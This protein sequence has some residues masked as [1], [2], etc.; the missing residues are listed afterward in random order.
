M[1]W[2]LMDKHKKDGA[3]L[4]EMKKLFVDLDKDGSG[5]ITKE[6]WYEVLNKS[7]HP[8]SMDEV[9]EFFKEK[10]KDLDGKLS[11]EEFCGKETKTEI[12]FHLLDRTHDGF[13]TKQDFA[14]LSSKL[15]PEQVDA[16]FKK[17]DKSHNGKL[18]YEEFC[19]MM[20]HRDSV[21]KKKKEE[22][23]ERGED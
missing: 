14:Q 5:K 20:N 22:E 3:K 10:D 11:W 17:F 19:G 4:R 16:V 21:K 15:S 12:A 2:C 1:S 6:E 8:T 7:G 13:I 23:E 9:T 18:D